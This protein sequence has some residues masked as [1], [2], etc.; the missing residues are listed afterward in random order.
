VLRAG[1]GE[2][3]GAHVVLRAAKHVLDAAEAA[4]ERVENNGVELGSSVKGGLALLLAVSVLQGIIALQI[5]RSVGR[6][7]RG[8]LTISGEYIS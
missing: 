5:S 6:G 8:A 1:G 4:P 7:R 2:N 3:T